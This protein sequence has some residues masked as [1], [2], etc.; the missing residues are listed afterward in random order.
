MVD[1]VASLVALFSED[2]DFA[3]ASGGRVFGGE[4]PADEAAQ[5]PRRCL[6]VK[7][8]GG[9]SPFGDSY[10]RLD[11]QRVDLSAFGPTVADASALLGLAGELLFPIQRQVSAGVLLHSVASAGGF[12]TGR[13]PQFDWPRAWR[14]FQVLHSLT[15]V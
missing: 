3:A 8:S 10:L 1:L 6:V 5:M 14:S 2:A 11:A 13:D 15:E 7:A 4:L 9:V 12:W